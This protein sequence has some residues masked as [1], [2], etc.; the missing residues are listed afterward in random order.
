[1]KRRRT[2]AVAAS[3]ATFAALTL[4]ACSSSTSSSGTG[5]TGG[6][7][8]PSSSAASGGAA[9]FN[10]GT[11]SVVNPSTTKTN[12]TLSFAL[13][14]TPDSLDP[15]N[16]YYAWTWNFTRLYA[17][18]LMTY[19]SA[20]G[21]AG[22]TLVPGLATAPGTASADGLTWTYHIKAGLKF[23]DGEPITSA[24]VK[25]AV[26]RTY[27]RSVLENGPN[28]FQVLL[29]DPKYPGPYKDP[30]GNLTSITT[31]NATT[32]EFHLLSPF[33]DFN[34][35]A[36]IPQTAPVPQDK[37]TG[38]N[39]Q[40]DPVSS[41]PYMFQSYS[42]NKEAVLVDNPNWVPSEDPQAEQLV[43]KVTL[44]MN[45]NADD[46]DNRLLAGDLDVDAAGTG[47]QA[48]AR[49][50]ILSS[51]TLMKSADDA[52]GNRLWFI[53]LNTKVAPLTNAACR[54]AIE[55]AADKT[56]LQT[57]YGGP[58]AGGSIATT[59]L[60]PGMPGYTSFDLYH[61][62]SQPTGDDTDAKAALAKCGQPNGF[63]VGAAYR[64]DRPKEVQAAQALQAS[65][66]KVGIT[67]QLHGYPSGTYYSD[68]AGSPNY[69]HTHDL[70]IDFGGWSP[71]W[72]DGYGML[73]ELVNGNT[74]VPAGNTNIS[75]ENNPQVNAL[76][77]DA[78]KPT[79][80]PAQQAADY[81]Q[82][83]K[84]VMQDAVILP[85]VYGKSLLYRG[86]DLTNV[87]AYAPFGMYNYAVL[88]KS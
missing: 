10:A 25:Y 28:Y 83:D 62:L 55:Y 85:E 58:Y 65:L 21:A 6:G 15:G 2:L 11:T 59:T 22:N 41:G 24:D 39:Y 43:S 84:L 50:K 47:V 9:A 40:L 78:A 17:T 56:D 64:S 80:S 51:P 31:P 7:S 38:A 12:A 48:A 19:K 86:S 76:F 73:D 20:P 57:A 54:Q 44:T 75:E 60:L 26:E 46:I 29:A 1:M 5:A 23:S 36:A 49:A 70:G 3:A 72:P 87:Y 81:G 42:L 71:D 69:V 82:I 33:P 88:G 37:D 34:Y 66:A 35:V 8:S 63:T 45:V 74:I 4:A 13:S 53:Y 67:L 52:L 16:T 30:K 14:S 61:A 68:F 27:D 18:P 32:I 79:T 77:T